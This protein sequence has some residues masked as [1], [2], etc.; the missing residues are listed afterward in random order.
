MSTNYFHETPEAFDRLRRQRVIAFDTVKDRTGKN[1]ISYYRFAHSSKIIFPDLYQEIRGA[2]R[3]A[4]SPSFCTIQIAHWVRQN[5]SEVKGK[6]FLE[7]IAGSGLIAIAAVKSHAKEAIALDLRG[8]EVVKRNAKANKVSDAVSIVTDN[9]L[10]PASQR[11]IEKADVISLCNAFLGD[12]KALEENLLCQAKRG[13][14][15]I[16]C[17]F[18]R[19]DGGWQL[20]SQHGRPIRP[21]RVPEDYFDVEKLNHLKMFKVTADSINFG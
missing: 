7:L 1:P 6:I 15:V 5:P 13:A 14:T 4:L 21:H 20:L 2:W 10:S 19:S 18:A 8:A 16:G 9:I 17:A 11:L 12:H 3:W